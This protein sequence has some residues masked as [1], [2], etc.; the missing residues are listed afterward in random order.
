MRILY[1]LGGWKQFCLGDPIGKPQKT[2]NSR[3]EATE[4]C[5]VMAVDGLM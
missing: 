4:S 2:I 1:A 5:T 3:Q